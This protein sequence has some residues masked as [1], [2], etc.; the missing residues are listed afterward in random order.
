MTQYADADMLLAMYTLDE[1]DNELKE[2]NERGH[3][4]LSVI[5]ENIKDCIVPDVEKKLREY[6]VLAGVL[7]IMGKATNV[8]TEPELKKLVT[9]LTGKGEEFYKAVDDFVANECEKIR[10]EME[11]KN[12]TSNSDGNVSPANLSACECEEQHTWETDDDFCS[13]GEGIDT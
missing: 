12:E 3:V 13:Y 2:L 9:G 4:P 5:R 6:D 1:N 7:Y 10:L 8:V 11:Q